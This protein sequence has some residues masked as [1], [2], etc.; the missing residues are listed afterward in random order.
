MGKY[1]EDLALRFIRE[2]KLGPEA[3]EWQNPP[4]SSDMS[5]HWFYKSVKEKLQAWFKKKRFTLATLAK[6]T[7]AGRS[8]ESGWYESRASIATVQGCE[9]EKE[10]G[11]LDLR[12]GPAVRFFELTPRAM[13]TELAMSAIAAEVYDELIYQKYTPKT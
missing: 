8:A 10:K 9:V 7:A 11:E 5:P 6:I 4:S 13:L 12:G 2:N 1:I 3:L